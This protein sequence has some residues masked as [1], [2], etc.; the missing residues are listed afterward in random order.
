M[1]IGR[2]LTLVFKMSA[3]EH[4]ILR[5]MLIEHIKLEDTSKEERELYNELVES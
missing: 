2:E 4:E 3:H 5:D 1:E